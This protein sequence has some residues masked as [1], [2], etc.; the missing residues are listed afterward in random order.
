MLTIMHIINYPHNPD[1]MIEVYGEPEN[2]CYEWRIIE[3]DGVVL[4]DTIDDGTKYCP[5]RQ[6]GSAEIALRDA[7]MVAS[8][9]NDPYPFND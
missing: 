6:Y 8:G 4:K 7:L 1:K 9:M 3:N 2:A 5:G